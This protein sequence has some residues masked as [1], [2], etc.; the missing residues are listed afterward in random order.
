MAIDQGVAPAPYDAVAS[1][2]IEGL[3]EIL[4]GGFLR[5]EL[6]LVQGTAGTG[7]TTLGLQFLIAGAAAGESSVY[8]TLAQSKA[9]LEA[10]ARSHGWSLAGVTVYE[11]L[12]SGVVE[13]I[14]A[15]QTVL[16]T[17]EVELSELTRTLRRLVG[18]MK[19]R[20]LVLDSLGVI[21]L[22]AGSPPRFQREIVG[23][24]QF[25]TS[26]GCTAVFLGDWPVDATVESAANTELH[27]LAA[28][29]IHLDQTAP[30][31]GDV[32]RRMRVIKVRG[33]DFDGGYHN[34]RIR[35]GGLQVY[36]R[37]AGYD[38][39]EYSAFRHIKSGIL[40][41]DELLGGG[42]EQGT[43]C[44][45]VGPS[46]AGKST[47]A[48]VFCRAAAQAGHAASIFLFE[49]RPETFKVR[50]TGVGIDVESHV[51]SGRIQIQEL[52]PAG[53]SPGEFA[54]QVRTAVEGRGAR[55][56]LI[57]SITGYFNAMNNSPMLVIQMHEVLNYLSRHGV[58]TMLVVS[59]EG[60]MS[61]GP[62]STL[63]VSYLSD[64]ILLL[65]MF[66]AD[67]A[68]HRCIAAVKKRQ[69]EHETTIRELFIRPGEVTVGEPLNRLRSILSG[70]PR[71]VAGPNGRPTP[72]EGDDE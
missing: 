56:V 27:V 44:L 34:F 12:T 51:Q 48:A 20:R 37:L 4:H 2:G 5:G 19:P 16:H 25:L 11:M 30:E 68:I 38:A 32:R 72:P 64:S 3:D 71:P 35:K 45:F 52:R 53:I 67:G 43:T 15:H 47:L 62:P 41:L 28:S 18:Q 33:I 14:V 69:G 7:K 61:V 17:A 49:E 6:H 23:L 8:V 39:P 31:Y 21:G 60:F 50:S 10:I 46:G 70:D 26:H 63:D 1:T 40:A 59:Q 29:L 57:D 22:L 66:E 9:L 54:Q 13:D 42:L 24:R 58:L 65:R 55:V 36:P